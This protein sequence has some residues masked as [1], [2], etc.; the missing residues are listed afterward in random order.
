MQT[1]KAQ[2]NSHIPSGAC[3]D[4]LWYQMIL[5]ADIQGLNRLCEY[6]GR[7]GPLLSIYVPK[8][9]FHTDGIILSY[10]CINSQTE[11]CHAK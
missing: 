11:C 7:P 4:N 5:S 6:A 10:S 9:Y 1:V 3:Q 8:V 2:I